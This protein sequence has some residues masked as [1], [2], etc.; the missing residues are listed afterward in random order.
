M[1]VEHVRGTRTVAGLDAEPTSPAE[2]G[3]AGGRVRYW[4]E[5][6]E[7]SA[8]ASVNS[9]YLL[10]RLPSAARVTGLS[11]LHHDDLAS[12]GSPVIDL[13]IFNP[14]GETGITDDDDA[15]IDGTNVSTA[16]ASVRFPADITKVGRR[17]W[18]L[19]ANQTTDPGGVLDIKAT[20]KT[21][22]TNTGGTV[23]LEL[24]YTVD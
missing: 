6:V 21:A 11:V 3:W 14:A 22:A 19:V 18:E 12:T 9:T 15:L 10:A 20:I 17:L 8:A 2:V 4:S 16:A 1:A 7:V 24:F 5:T 13:G 23:T